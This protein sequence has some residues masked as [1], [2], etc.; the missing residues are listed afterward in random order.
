MSPEVS[1]IFRSVLGA[2]PKYEASEDEVADVLSK[3]EAVSDCYGPSSS[4]HSSR[5]YW[6]RDSVTG[7]YVSNAALP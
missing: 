5:E 2:K 7:N 4:M 1:V 6:D 3:F